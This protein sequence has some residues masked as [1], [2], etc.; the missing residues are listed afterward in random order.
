MKTKF[1]TLLIAASALAIGISSVPV[2]AREQ[3]NRGERPSAAQGKG[4][5]DVIPVTLP[6]DRRPP[7][8]TS[9][10]I[11]IRKETRVPPLPYFR[12]R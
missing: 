4:F 6:A 3:M 1:V 7:A 10:G 5:G 8:G 12:P 9:T 11:P 2:S